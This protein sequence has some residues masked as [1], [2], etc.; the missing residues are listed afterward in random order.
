MDNFIIFLLFMLACTLALLLMLACDMGKA[1]LL[2]AVRRR[3]KRR[4]ERAYGGKR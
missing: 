2:Q 1:W 3:N 4:I